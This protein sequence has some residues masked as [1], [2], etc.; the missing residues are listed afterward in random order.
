V[1]KK[2]A[3]AQPED[4]GDDGERRRARPG[5]EEVAGRAWRRRRSGA[6][7]QRAGLE[8]AKGD[9]EERSSGMIGGRRQDLWRR[10]PATAPSMSAKQTPLI[11]AP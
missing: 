1:K 9:K 7:G 6:A 10:P 8:M 11:L 2:G 5:E 3:G 4:A